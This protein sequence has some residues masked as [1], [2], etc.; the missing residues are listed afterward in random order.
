MSKKIK[1]QDNKEVFS[2][3]NGRAGLAT[4][5]TG[6]RFQKFNVRQKMLG[7]SI[8]HVCSFCS[9]EIV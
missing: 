6:S 8:S 7:I 5:E 4:N 1:N 2:L 9:D 3:S